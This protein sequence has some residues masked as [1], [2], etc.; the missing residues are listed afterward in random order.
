M[1]LQ[2]D[3]SLSLP[4]TDDVPQLRSFLPI[5]ANT[6]IMIERYSDSAAAYVMLDPSNMAVY[7]QLYRAAKAKSRLKFRV[8]ALPDNDE[9]TSPEVKPVP[10]AAIPKIESFNAN[11]PPSAPPAPTEP[12]A[13]TTST[14][15]PA[16][17]KAEAAQASR[18]AQ[19]AP[20]ATASSSKTPTSRTFYTNLLQ[21]APIMTQNYK[22]DLDHRSRKFMKTR[23][24]LVNHPSKLISQPFAATSDSPK[25][26]D[27]TSPV[28]PESA[29]TKATFAVCCNFCERNIPDTHYHCSIC[30]DG[31]FDL[32]PSCHEQDITCNGDHHWLIKRTVSNGQIV[33]STTETISPKLKAKS[34]PP[35]EP[36]KPS[37]DLDELVKATANVSIEEAAFSNA[38]PPADVCWP[39]SSDLR[40][41]N[42]CVRGERFP[43]L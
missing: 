1:C 7:K 14:A 37:D 19:A 17:Q 40:T 41:C 34:E 31:D 26:S 10:V 15:A 42:Q 38:F 23:D 4:R 20:L 28:C 11:P 3:S 6:N 8:S 32:C 24:D 29:P 5:P 25:L 39:V 12:K 16:A 36:A 9:E 2:H 21:E 33:N 18:E 35:T 27:L 22:T 13:S 43:S 30:N